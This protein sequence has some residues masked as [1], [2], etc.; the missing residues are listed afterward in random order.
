MPA[1]S[2]DGL[3]LRSGPDPVADLTVG[4]YE[5][6]GDVWGVLSGAGHRRGYVTGT[7]TG[8]EV[9]LAL[10]TL[11][12]AGH[13]RGLE[14]RG[15]VL[16]HDGQV[17]LDMDWDIAPARLVSTGWLDPSGPPPPPDARPGPTGV[18]RLVEIDE[19]NLQEVLRVRT[20]PH[21]EDYVADNGRSIA[22]GLLCTPP[23][24]YRA[25]YDAD[26]CVGFVMLAHFDDPAHELYHRYHGWYLWRLLIGAAHQR[27]GYGA[28]VM[29]LV[30]RHIDEQGGPRRL[31]TS[32]NP[33]L[34]G[35]ERFY[36]GLG[37][38]PTG[39]IDEGEV[40]AVLARWP[41]PAEANAGATT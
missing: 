5:W 23:G 2:L 12:D 27:R 16:E 3:Q 36:R 34:G 24:W 14:V 35:P 17:A 20:A 10:A 7:R 9:V 31:T 38:E 41:E 6:R 25:V 26:V 13:A 19:H 21:Q 15:V 30:Y 8:D 22:E 39:E 11:D 33:D 40:V 32:W 37:F 18:V 29:H 1:P 28:Q 4:L